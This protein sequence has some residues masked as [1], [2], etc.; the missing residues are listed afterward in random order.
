MGAS[1]RTSGTVFNDMIFGESIQYQCFFFLQN[2][3]MIN[4]MFLTYSDKHL[5][6]IASACCQTRKKSDNSSADPIVMPTQKFA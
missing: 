6:V 4:N 3:V 5:T 1:E 2:T